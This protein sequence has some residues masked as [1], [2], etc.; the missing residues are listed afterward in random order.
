VTIEEN[1]IAGGAG[2]AVSEYLDSSPI[3]TSILHLGFPDEYVEQGERQ[4]VLSSWGLDE[5]GMTKSILNHL[6]MELPT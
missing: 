2:S 3:K 4:E 5:K 1:A 6:G